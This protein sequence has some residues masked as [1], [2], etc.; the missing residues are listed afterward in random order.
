MPECPVLLRLDQMFAGL[1]KYN[2]ADVEDLRLRVRHQ[3]VNNKHF[4]HNK[5]QM[6]PQEQ[7][8]DHT[9]GERDFLL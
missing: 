6:H 1:F 4:Q 2:R 7:Q 3:M 9:I 8:V 5:G